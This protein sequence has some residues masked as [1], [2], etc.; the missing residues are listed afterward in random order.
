M[1][2]HLQIPNK[3]PARKLLPKS[4]Q[5][6]RGTLVFN[7]GPQEEMGVLPPFVCRYFTEYSI[8][9]YCISLIL[10]VVL[11][12]DLE[13]TFLHALSQLRLE[14]IDCVIVSFPRIIHFKRNQ[15]SQISFTYQ[16]KRKKTY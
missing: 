8:V 16:K 3:G 15:T 6:A 2:L 13:R 14:R 7:D 9:L 10:S 1:F 12:G 11:P 4:R 5:Y